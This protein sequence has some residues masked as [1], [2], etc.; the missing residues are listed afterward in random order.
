MPVG[1]VKI[2]SNFCCPKVSV[3]RAPLMLWHMQVPL[4]AVKPR[5]SADM[6]RMHAR[7]GRPSQTN[8]GYLAHIGDDRNIH[9]DVH[10][11][12]FFVVIHLC[13]VAR[14]V[15]FAPGTL[16]GA[17]GVLTYLSGAF[18]IVSR[19]RSRDDALR[20]REGQTTLTM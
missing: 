3:L 10:R 17:G 18:M 8:S 16:G 20:R 1:E 12:L 4:F 7:A 6:L 9:I 11:G 19:H 14:G 5:G 15:F 2:G 13:C